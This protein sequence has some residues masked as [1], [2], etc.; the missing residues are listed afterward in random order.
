MAFAS[1]IKI[2][3]FSVFLYFLASFLLLR[4]SLKEFAFEKDNDETHPIHYEHKKQETTS[5]RYLLYFT[6]S[7]FSNQLI[8]LKN[9]VEFAHATGRTLVL[10]PVLPHLAKWGSPPDWNGRPL[11]IGCRPYNTYA[12]RLEDLKVDTVKAADYE[13]LE[14]DAFPSFRE[15]IDFS[16]L[17]NLT[18]VEFI[19]MPDFVRGQLLQQNQSQ[20]RNYTAAKAIK[21]QHEHWCT[22]SKDMAKKLTGG[23]EHSEVGNSYFHIAEFFNKSCPTDVAMI[24]SAYVIPPKFSEYNPQLGEVIYNSV[25]SF[26]MSKKLSQLVKLVHGRLQAGY[27]GVHIR[28]KDKM[29]VKCID[30]AVEKV[31]KEIMQDLQQKNV[32]KGAQILIGNSDKMARPCF[33]FHA[34]GLYSAVTVNGVIDGNEEAQRLVD[35]IKTEKSAIFITLDQTLIAAADIVIEKK[36]KTTAHTFQDVINIRHQWNQRQ[37]VLAKINESK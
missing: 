28:F 26:P 35:D 4:S 20:I 5:R 11:G 25:L 3:L 36:V 34:D 7:G 27:V 9:A 23:C 29:Q 37:K 22:A 16:E 6:H 21:K 13:G 12:S 2:A 24:A 19:D 32:T 10:P 8:G 17:T 1:K 31:Y 33:E 18:G 15:L 14:Y 30:N